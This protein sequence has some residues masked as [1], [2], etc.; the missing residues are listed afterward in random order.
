MVT[1]PTQFSTVSNLLDAIVGAVAGPFVGPEQS[2]N[3][4]RS[5]IVEL[6]PTPDNLLTALVDYHTGLICQP[7][8]EALGDYLYGRVRTV[9]GRLVQAG[10]LDDARRYVALNIEVVS[11]AAEATRHM[12]ESGCR[13]CPD[14]WQHCDALERLESREDSLHQQIAALGGW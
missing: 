13:L 1:V 8:R 7:A 2:A 14:L 11:V 4:L 6:R 12:H 3:A 10:R 5:R 9:A